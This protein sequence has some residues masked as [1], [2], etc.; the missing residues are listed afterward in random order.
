MIKQLLIIA[1]SLLVSNF[2]WAQAGRL[3][4]EYKLDIPKAEVT[5]LWNFLNDNFGQ[6]TFDLAGLTLSGQPSTEVFIDKYF[7]MPDGRFA[8]GEISL[9]HRKRFKDKI[10]LKQLVQL[11]TPYSED[12]VIRNEIK[13]EVDKS[14]NIQDPMRRHDLL[15]YI[16]SS[17]LERLSYHLAPLKLR[18]EALELSLKLI[19]TRNRIYISDSTGESIATLTLDEVTLSRFPFTAYA[20]IE[21]ELN[22]VRFT[23]ANAQEREKM[24]ALNEAL[25]SQLLENFPRLKV[26]Q[27]SKYRKMRELVD[28]STAASIYDNGVWFL[29][30][31][32]TL[33][34][35]GFFIKDQLL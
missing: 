23:Q 9:R 13:F 11:K 35:A 7:D 4:S 19:Q 3:E 27:R 8:K 1:A 18:P 34:A 5:P 14:K 33:L 15:Q 31:C 22:E 20:E 10:L 28:D 21:L 30:G 2:L 17:D 6:E 16:K 12:K 29:F 26:D 32:I 24:T 25:K